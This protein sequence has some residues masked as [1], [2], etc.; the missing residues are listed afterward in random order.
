MRHRALLIVLVL[1]L[2]VLP[3]F[4]LAE[5]FSPLSALGVLAPSALLGATAALPRPSRTLRSC[6]CALAL[7][8]CS[9]AFVVFWHGT[10][11]A[12]FHYFVM[13]AAL[14]LYEE[15]IVYG[16]A[17]GY[18]VLQHGIMGQ[19]GGRTVFAH[20]MDMAGHSKWFWAAIHGAFIGA[21]A[22]ANV[23]SWRASEGAR[24]QTADALEVVRHQADHDAP[25]GLVSRARF[26]TELDAT[27]A[28]RSDG[29]VVGVLFVDL[30]DFKHVND[31]QGHVLGDELLVI[32]ARRLLDGVRPTDVVGRFGGDAFAL[33][34]RATSSDE[35]EH[36]ADRLG[37]AL[38]APLVLGDRPR[39]ITASVGI[40]VADDR[41]V[42]GDALIR[43]ADA[44]MYVA[45]RRG[46]ARRQRF[47]ATLRA[48]AL[49]SRV[50]I[51]SPARPAGSARAQPDPP[52]PSSAT[53]PAELDRVLEED[54]I[55]SAY[56]PIVDL[57]TG[58]VI[59]YEALARGPEGSSLERPD[60]LFAAGRAA[61]RL[62]ELDWACRA[63]AVRGARGVG[64][65]GLQR[66]FVNVEPL[67]LM[68][69]P[70]AALRDLW[71]ETGPELVIELTERA[72]TARP[73]E[74]L[75][76]VAVIRRRGWAVAL[77]DVGADA[78]SLA[79]MPLLQPEIIKLDLRLVQQQAST[80][81][82]EIIHAVSAESER[83]GAIILAEGIETEE[84]LATARALGAT[85]GQGWFFGRPGP[86]PAQPRA[87]VRGPLL[88]PAP[89]SV[90]VRSG[91]P[92]AAVA[93]ERAVR[94]GDKRLLLSISRRLEQHAAELGR[95]GILLGAFQGAE[96]FT[97]DTR[98][99]YELLAA[100][101]ALVAAF[102]VGME[103]EPAP[104][105]RGADLGPDD[106]LRDE[107]SVVV[108]G[109]HFSAAL[110]AVD[111]GDDGPDME[112]GFDFTL[113]YDRQLVIRAAATL[114]GRTLP[115]AV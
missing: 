103:G 93:R 109:P 24:R 104:G 80:D 35:L 68:V 94:R 74:L 53:D 65:N 88:A 52:A 96:R 105:V 49:A 51:G 47:D 40:A 89:T 30:D 29:S 108:L 50:R 98:R 69:P 5:G 8:S 57:A 6:A 21:L 56:Q 48:D 83:T 46:K 7:L 58:D 107:W 110:V 13:T 55:R 72:L 31:S 15:W 76:A 113:T 95:S 82:A 75:E 81:L 38:V 114:M 78:R 73:A 18:V 22:V 90:S 16:L 26:S 79:L 9:A 33:C 62:D 106:V 36:V 23:A 54:A 34:V 44:A 20:P 112:R 101:A 61:G 2:I 32:V 10:I 60:L 12:H 115:V 28:A 4:A 19:F 11:E 25:T 87:P 67:A 42:Q 43:D 27:L 86:M 45:K 71:E 41:A 70:P 91:P 85:V 63:A 102:G 99:R 84:H 77:D 37:L 1:H 14:A 66:L 64:G 92:Y 100:D 111:L 59:G 97:P 3:S 39:S 17:V